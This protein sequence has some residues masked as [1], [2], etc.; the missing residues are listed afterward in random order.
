LVT[1]SLLVYHPAPVDQYTIHRLTYLFLWTLQRG[2]AISL[3]DT[4]PAVP[5]QRLSSA[6]AQKKK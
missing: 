6:K 5:P 4:K 3:I 1:H 2:G